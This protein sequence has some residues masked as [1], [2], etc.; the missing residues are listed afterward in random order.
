MASRDEILMNFMAATGSEDFGKAFQLL[1]S[2]DW[3]FENALGLFHATDDDHPDPNKILENDFKPAT[4]PFDLLQNNQSSSTSSRN[5]TTASNHTPISGKIFVKIKNKHNGRLF[6]RYYDPKTKVVN[7]RKDASEYFSIPFDVAVWTCTAIDDDPLSSINKQF[8][9]LEIENLL[10][11]IE[12]TNDHTEGRY[13]NV[14]DLSSGN[15][16]DNRMEISDDEDD[17][18]DVKFVSSSNSGDKKSSSS[19]KVAPKRSNCGLLPADAQ[20]NTIPEAINY[21]MVIKT[22]F[23]Y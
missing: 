10:A 5:N 6:E 20:F 15:N 1:E 23:F 11:D 3:N 2:T 18:D 8:L 4:N 14:V 22:L 17:S 13:T 12:R 19:K 7:V 16:Q 21:R 9:D